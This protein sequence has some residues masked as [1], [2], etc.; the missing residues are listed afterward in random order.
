LDYA[1][2]LAS[3]YQASHEDFVSER[4]RLSAALKAAGDRDGAARLAK[5]GRPPIS[6]WAVNQLYWRERAAFDELFETARRLQHGDRSAAAPHRAVTLRLRAQASSILSDAGHASSDATLRRVT[7]TLGSLAATASFDPDPPGALSA[8]RDP[9]GFEAWGIANEPE[10]PSA[11]PEPSA[12]SS[13]RARQA[14][15]RRES[16]QREETRARERAAAEAEAERKRRAERRAERQAEQRRLA[17]AS[18]AASRELDEAAA[19][20]KSLE[21]RLQKAQAR[22]ET[23]RQALQQLEAEQAAASV[24]EDDE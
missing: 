1:S 6:A 9:P 8:D 14:E 7:A 3:L 12:G 16:E 2:A 5:L 15:R 18:E 11:A 20:V 17:A 21:S 13:E 22:V 10:E 19:E 24:G 4:K 23:A